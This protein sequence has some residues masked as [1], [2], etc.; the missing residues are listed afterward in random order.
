MSASLNIF[1]K[2]EDYRE[3]RITLQEL[4]SWLV[5]RLPIFLSNPD[6]DVAR[7]IGAVELCL[8]EF[9]AGIRTERGIRIYLTRHMPTTRIAWVPYPDESSEEQASSTFTTVG[10]DYTWSTQPQPWHNAPQVVH[11]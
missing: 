7:L 11:V 1:S 9:Q 4:E 3:H 10:N 2:V 8:A 5:P 6:S